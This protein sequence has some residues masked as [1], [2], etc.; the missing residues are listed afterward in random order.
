METLCIKAFVSGLSGIPGISGLSG[1]CRRTIHE[2]AD[3]LI[4]IIR[5][6]SGWEPKAVR[7]AHYINWFARRTI[8]FPIT[9]IQSSGLATYRNGNYMCK[10]LCFGI[11]SGNLGA[12]RRKFMSAANLYSE[13]TGLS[14]YF[15]RQ[16]PCA[17]RTI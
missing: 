11:L 8:S 12:V 6:M 7:E 4:W 14:Q 10:G 1:M 2:A 15:E 16:R 3:Y 17:K 13:P 9:P 5:K